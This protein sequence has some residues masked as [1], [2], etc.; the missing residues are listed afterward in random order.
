[1]NSKNTTLV[2]ILIFL[3]VLGG[4]IIWQ[5]VRE[6]RLQ[7]IEEVAPQLITQTP[8]PITTPV[9]TSAS[10]LSENDVTK[11]ALCVEKGGIYDAA[12]AE[13][14][15]ISSIDCVNIGGKEIVCGSACRH[16]PAAEICTMEC[17][18]YCQM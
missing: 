9:A 15:N 1:M 2:I 7:T 11:Q 3:L 10:N 6:N 5:M 13:C 17:V 12:Y 14:S 4:T 16:D 8:V 18:A